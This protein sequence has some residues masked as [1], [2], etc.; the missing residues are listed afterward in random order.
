MRW[1]LL[2]VAAMLGALS[3]TLIGGNTACIAT[4]AGAGGTAT[5]SSS[6]T[7]YP[8]CDIGQGCDACRECASLGACSLYVQE[9]GAN[10][11]C[12]SID[13]GIGSCELTI[14]PDPNC[15]AGICGPDMPT[16]PTGTELY[17]AAAACV[18]ESQCPISCTGLY[19]PCNGS[20]TQ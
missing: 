16:D 6:S 7:V 18:F 15:L 13:Q 17:L 8:A 10:P 2:G 12:V 1:S 19:Y 20:F 3:I 11:E 14:P 9:C 4:D 5:T